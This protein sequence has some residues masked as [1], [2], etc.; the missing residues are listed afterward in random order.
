[1]RHATFGK[2]L[3]RDIKARKALLNNLAN[4]LLLH[5]SLQTTQAKAKFAKVYVEKIVTLAKR[6]RLN[7]DR[8]LASYLT[9]EAFTKLTKEIAPGFNQRN[10]GYTRIIKLAPRKGDA[11]KMAKLELLPWQKPEGKS[12]QAKKALAKTSTRQR[13][14]FREAKEANQKKPARKPKQAPKKRALTKKGK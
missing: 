9:H 12:I 1:M 10:G 3:S 11:A 4:S 14:G 13:P 8:A 6:N 2:R 7:S 5:G